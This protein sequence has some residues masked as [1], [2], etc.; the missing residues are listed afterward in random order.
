MRCRP[1]TGDFLPIKAE[2][3][4][5][6]VS[7]VLKLDRNVQIALLTVI[8]SC[9]ILLATEGVRI[10]SIDAGRLLPVRRFAGVLI[11]CV[12]TFGADTSV[13]QFAGVP[14]CCVERW[15]LI[16][17]LA[18]RRLPVAGRRYAASAVYQSVVLN[19]GI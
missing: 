1:I 7:S 19:V 14:I 6:R 15:N 17:R 16:R 2:R 8:S 12:V 11:C 13:R 4:C 9:G 10:R 5:C 3:N 18:G